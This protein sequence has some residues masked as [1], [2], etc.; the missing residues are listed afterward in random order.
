MAKY[1]L[2][3]GHIV[4]NG[5][6]EYLDGAILIEGDKILDVFPDSRI[7][8]GDFIEINLHGQIVMPKIYQGELSENIQVLNTRSLKSLVKLSSSDDYVMV[9]VDKIDDDTLLFIRKNINRNRFVLKS[10][11]VSEAFARMKK[12]G[13][14]Y[15]DLVLMSSINLYEASGSEVNGLLKGLKSDFVV[16][17]RDFHVIFE[18]DDGEFI[19]D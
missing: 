15:C 9:D 10:L 4:P 7:E 11:N 5:N 12:L 1:L 8:S 6:R 13:F 14:S 18:V 16:L 17:D 19:Y 3:H 2:S